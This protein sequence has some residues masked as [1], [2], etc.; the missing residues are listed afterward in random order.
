MLGG[1]FLLSVCLLVSFSQNKKKIFHGHGENQANAGNKG[2]KG[3][4]STAASC[5]LPSALSLADMLVVSASIFSRKFRHSDLKSW[6]KQLWFY[7]SS[8]GTGLHRGRWRPHLGRGNTGIQGQPNDAEHQTTRTKRKIETTVCQKVLHRV[9]HWPRS[10][11]WGHAKNVCQLIS[12]FHSASQLTQNSCHTKLTTTSSPVLLFW[13]SQVQ[14]S[15]EIGTAMP[16]TMNFCCE[17][18]S[19]LSRPPFLGNI[20]RNA[21]LFARI[22]WINRCFITTL[23]LIPFQYLMQKSDLFCTFFIVFIVVFETWSSSERTVELC[24]FD[25]I[26]FSFV[27]I[28]TE[29]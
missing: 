13:T 8:A 2:V 29:K 26:V 23:H 17:L 21:I 3:H 20:L 27:L 19:V 24:V 6:H 10:Y 28:F 7:V 18:C 1:Y 9:W 16:L 25:R 12:V 15:V 22:D 5:K 11:Y 4:Q 14:Y